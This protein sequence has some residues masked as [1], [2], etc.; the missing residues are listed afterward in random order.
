MFD[1]ASVK[2][3]W[4]SID[5]A[6]HPWLDGTKEKNVSLKNLEAPPRF[7]RLDILIYYLHLRSS[8]VAIGFHEG[9]SLSLY[10]S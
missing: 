8:T 10:S 7:C 6:T 2:I 5:D 3:T 1:V 9:K 4:V